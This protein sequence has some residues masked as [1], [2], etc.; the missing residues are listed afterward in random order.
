MALPMAAW[1]VNY[2]PG[3]WLVLSGPTSLFVMPP[4]PAKS[5]GFVTQLWASMLKADSVGA[6][7][8]LVAAE[9]LDTLV[10]LGA[11]FWDAEGLHGLTRGAVRV[12]DDATEDVVLDGSGVVTW[13]E[14]P[15]AIGKRLRIDLDPVD[16]DA[17][18]PLVVGAARASRLWLS[19]STADLLPVPT[20]DSADVLPRLEVLG[21]PDDDAEDGEDSVDQVTPVSPEVPHFEPEPQVL[22]TEDIQ[23]GLMEAA[24]A[25]AVPVPPPA[26]PVPAP[27]PEVQASASPAVPETAPEQPAAAEPQPGPEVISAD[28]VL[29]APCA[30]GHANSPDVTVCRL[31]QAPVDQVNT[32]L[33]TRP[34]LAGVHTN[35]GDFVDVVAGVVVG[36]APDVSKGPDGSRPLRVPSPSS[37]ISR[38]HV[39]ITTCDWD[40]YATDLQSTN[41]TMVLPVG[42]APYALQNSATVKVA[43]G[44]VLDLGDG[45]SI[46]IEPPRG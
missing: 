7:M 5:S 13:R 28:Q 11:Y 6:M 24:A 26:V 20:D 46:R 8:T 17:R 45:V 18:L 39:L 43:I 38:N 34:T 30:N 16:D 37:D 19:T 2:T 35:G 21:R 22:H 40:V 31:C 32:R 15:L 4:G 41:G 25:A 9:G 1:R 12:I 36:R 44:T 27:A 42:E 33:I 10:D 14:E 29:A 3:D 23:V